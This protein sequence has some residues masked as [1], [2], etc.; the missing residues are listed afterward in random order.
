VRAEIR[1]PENIERYNRIQKKKEY[2]L[3]KC[4]VIAVWATFVMVTIYAGI[5]A[6]QLC[7]MRRA[8]KAAQEANNLSRAFVGTFS[9]VLQPQIGRVA[10]E[11]GNSGRAIAVAS[12]VT[13]D[14]TI[15]RLSDNS[16]IQDEHREWNGPI[17][18]QGNFDKWFDISGTWPSYP[19]KREQAISQELWQDVVTV[20]ANIIYD[21]GFGKVEQQPFCR[22]FVADE[23][24][25]GPG[26][27]L[28]MEYQ[29]CDEARPF[30]EARKRQLGIFSPSQ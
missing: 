11:L 1:L 18:V 4:N 26:K 5:A 30:I 15:Q 16:M 29:S 8:T 24:I 3:A 14:L 9:V 23:R 2:S 27:P 6:W 20:K 19:H 25:N 7:E 13:A 21:S 10:F 17:Y 22:S 28:G 12:S